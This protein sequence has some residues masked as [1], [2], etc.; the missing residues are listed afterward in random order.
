MA[1][2]ALMGVIALPKLSGFFGNERKESS[3]L[4]A[5]IEAVAD[6]SFVKRRTNYLCIHLSRPGKKNAELF[7]DKFNETNIVSV[8]ELKDGKFIQN[9]SNILKDRSF[10]TSFSLDEVILEGGKVISSGNVLIPFYSDGTSVGFVIK[11]SSGESKINVIKNK[12]SKMVQLE[13]EI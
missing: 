6:D 7:N 4:C 13:N 8:Y 1:I 5:Y 9:S 2:I 11:I 10:S 12:I 3:I